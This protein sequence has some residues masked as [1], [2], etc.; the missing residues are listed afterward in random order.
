MITTITRPP[1]SQP[2]WGTYIGIPFGEAPRELTCWGLVRRI[3][4]DRLGID[5]PA[6][7][8]VSARDLARIARTM[9]A[10][11]DDGWRLPDQP[12]AYDVVLMRGHGGGSRA[13]HVGV[14]VDPQRMIHVEAAS[15][16]VV[17]PTRH[18][19]VAERIL[20]YRRHASQC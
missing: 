5:L 12:Q 18:W 11:Q 13:V 6:Y 20:G 8:E 9:A 16:T 17:V 2:W 7:G 1:S 4:A 3:Y 10:H 14:L 19:S 15:A